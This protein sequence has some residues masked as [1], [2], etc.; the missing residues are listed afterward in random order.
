MTN[1]VLVLFVML[2]VGSKMTVFNGGDAG[3]S[4][5]VVLTKKTCQIDQ[6]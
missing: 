3:I 6:N 2:V 5:S 1:A 4:T